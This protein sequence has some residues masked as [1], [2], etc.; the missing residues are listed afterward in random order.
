M[1]V[2]FRR[3]RS[4]DSLSAVLS[5]SLAMKRMAAPADDEEA[6]DF[7]AGDPAAA[8]VEEAAPP[9]VSQVFW[10][11]V[12]VRGTIHEAESLLVV[13]LLLLVATR[14]LLLLSGRSRYAWH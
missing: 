3:C 10:P 12:A 9:A 1:C 4:E 7:A 6:E 2:C 14:T 11:R 13:L 5:S 8:P